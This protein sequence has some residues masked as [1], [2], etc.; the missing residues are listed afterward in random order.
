M[1]GLE[2]GG[3]RKKERE[4]NLVEIYMDGGQHMGTMVQ[5]GL[6]VRRKTSER[7]GLRGIE[8]LV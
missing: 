5:S 6:H 3:G 8:Y 7:A 1:T 4:E 2:K